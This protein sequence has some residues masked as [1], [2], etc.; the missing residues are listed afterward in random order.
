[1]R[2]IK[3]VNKKLSLL[4][5]KIVNIEFS[6]KEKRSK[7]SCYYNEVRTIAIQSSVDGD[8]EGGVQP[9]VDDWSEQS[10]LNINFNK[11]HYRSKFFWTNKK[12]T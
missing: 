1:M 6:L 9:G 5:P 4:S 10:T 12:P 7:H 8:V 2:T 3:L 11:L